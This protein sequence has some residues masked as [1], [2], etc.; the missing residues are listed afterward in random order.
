MT[1]IQQTGKLSLFVQIITGLIDAFMLTVPLSQEHQILRQLLIMEL[2]VQVVEGIFYIWMIYKFSVISNVTMFRYWDWVF[3][4]PVM[5][6]TLSLYFLYK[7]DINIKEHN[8][9]T[10]ENSNIK[11]YQTTKEN[12]SFKSLPQYLKENYKP[13]S[14]IVIMNSLMLLFGYLGEINYLSVIKSTFYGFIPFVIMFY[15]IYTNF[16]Q[17]N[18]ETL[19]MF[20]YFVIVWGL[21]GIAA[22]F[23][24]K[25]KNVSYNILD[26][27]A[28][29]F[30]G[31][32]L[33]YVIYKKSNTNLYI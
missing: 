10:K 22:L 14:I 15:I 24:Y 18:Q 30:F 2:V 26:L 6:I 16:A 20:W 23:N 11:Y 13:L 19:N 17:V 8:S 1:L 28:K 21:Y 33:A 27:F 3:T 4:T 29:N 5:L 25:W 31:L 7:K 9:Q 12:N 32:F